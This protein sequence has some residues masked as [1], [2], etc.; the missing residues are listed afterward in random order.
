MVLM[1]TRK[2]FNYAL[3]SILVALDGFGILLSFFIYQKFFGRP[4]EPF[5]KVLELALIPAGFG[6]ASFFL[7]S[8]YRCQPGPL[9][10]DQLRRILSSYFWSGMMAFSLTFFTKAQGFSR[11]MVSMGFLLGII[12]VLVGRALF[13]RITA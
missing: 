12:F 9:G 10:L 1:G 13:V 7:T 8:V 4:P 2:S 6:V 11:I 5:E 3:N